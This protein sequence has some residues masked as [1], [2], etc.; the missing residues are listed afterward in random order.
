[1]DARRTAIA[2]WFLW[3][4]RTARAATFDSV[5][6]NLT[7]ETVTFS[8]AQLVPNTDGLR[9]RCSS[10]FPAGHALSDLEAEWLVRH[11]GLVSLLMSSC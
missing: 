9:Q 3:F 11:H 10:R 6:L 8:G 5:T 7:S 1:M 4:S 2:H